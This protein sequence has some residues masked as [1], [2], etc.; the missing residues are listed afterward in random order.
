MMS[1]NLSTRTMHIADWRFSIADLKAAFRQDINRQL[2][3]GNQQCFGDEREMESGLIF[4]QLICE[5]ESRR[6]CQDICE[7]DC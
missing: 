7:C 3:I 2:A 5:F 1:S 4:N 6:P